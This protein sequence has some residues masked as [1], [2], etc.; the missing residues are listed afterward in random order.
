ML[1]I[2]ITGA[3]SGLG[4]VV[5]ERFSIKGHRVF[6]CDASEDAIAELDR[7]GTVALATRVD[8]SDREQIELWFKDIFARTASLDVLVNNVGVAGPH[9]AVEEMELNDWHQTLDANLS[10]ALITTRLALPAMKRAMS[11]SI[12]NVST[13]SV[14]TNPAHRAPYV[15]SKAALEALT[16]AVA[17][18]AG[19]FNI[20]C[21]AVRPGMMNNE[22]L[23]RIL[24]RVA[25]QSG[26]TVEE[27]EGDQLRYIWMKKKVEMLEVSQLIEF[28]ASDAACSITGQ[29]IS[30]DGGMSWEE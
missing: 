6:A 4:R 27:V 5:A 11:G 28:L 18:E 23:M 25:A 16:L 2:A 21:N 20:R 22:R 7:S 19:P 24:R 26:R 29:I 30:V 9:A 10:S 8:V 1:N 14:L 12:I 17:R 15:V 3:A 13:I